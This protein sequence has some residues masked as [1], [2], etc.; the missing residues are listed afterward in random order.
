MA[1]ED[2]G[3]SLSLSRR[4]IPSALALVT[5]IAGSTTSPAPSSLLGGGSVTSSPPRLCD[6]SGSSLVSPSVAAGGLSVP[7]SC[8]KSISARTVAWSS[9]SSSPSSALV[10]P[11]MGEGWSGDD[12]ADDSS[13]GA[14]VSVICGMMLGCVDFASALTPS[15][16]SSMLLFLASG[17]RQRLLIRVKDI[18]PWL[19]GI[20]FKA[21]I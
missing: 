8:W 9:T 13:A 1:D 18:F 17:E 19:V 2:D 20:V 11:M 12:K 16:G 15:L 6:G 5:T 14:L 10:G 3:R 4:G 7:I 21:F